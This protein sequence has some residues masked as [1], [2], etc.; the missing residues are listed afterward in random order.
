MLDDDALFDVVLWRILVIIPL[1]F[2]ED[3]EALMMSVD[4]VMTLDAS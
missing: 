1:H 3:N 2:M 4:V